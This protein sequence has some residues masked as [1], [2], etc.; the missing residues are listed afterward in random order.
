MKSKI[1]QFIKNH[2]TILN[3]LILIYNLLF[4][5]SL[6][7]Y[8]FS[9]NIRC[10]GAFLK[11]CK[12][13]IIGPNNKIVIGQSASLKNCTIYMC[14]KNCRLTI[15]GGSTIVK[16]TTFY[17]EDDE[18]SIV[19]GKDFTMEGGHIAATEGKQITIGD[20]CMFSS[21]IE[22]RNGDSHVILDT[23]SCKRINLAQDVSIGD[24]V[25]LTAHVRVMK[26]SRIASHSVVGNSSLVVGDLSAEY[27]LYGGTPVRK[28]KDNITWERDRYKWKR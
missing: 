5:R 16:N 7:R 14:G 19:V 1:K 21:D 22:I 26:G 20:D 27:A 28:L 12:I 15:G 17:L 6:I 2:P 24:H 25:W 4:Q 9:G 18:C 8:V 3:L 23:T 10:D 11:G 13:K